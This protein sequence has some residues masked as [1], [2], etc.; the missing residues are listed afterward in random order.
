MCGAPRGRSL[1]QSRASC[2]I[3]SSSGVSFNARVEQTI[4]S[5]SPMIGPALGGTIVALS[6]A[7]FDAATGF[8]TVQYKPLAKC[9]VAN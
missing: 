7:R 5:I 9:L 3:D 4:S 8:G 2:S 6:G 1:H